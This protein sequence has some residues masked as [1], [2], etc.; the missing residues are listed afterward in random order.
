MSAL[1]YSLFNG[2]DDIA[3]LL[4]SNQHLNPFIK[5]ETITL[6]QQEGGG[7]KSIKL[8]KMIMGEVFGEKVEKAS[9]TYSKA[10]IISNHF[11]N[12]IKAQEN[13]KNNFYF[14]MIKKNN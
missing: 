10:N 14:G 11:I 13:E 7:E 4:F 3:E 8:L 5:T 9:E 12:T 6:L 2:Y 1:Y